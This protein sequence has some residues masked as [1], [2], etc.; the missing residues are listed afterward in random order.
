MPL[1]P[2]QEV[3]LMGVPLTKKGLQPYNPFGEYLSKF[4]TL[5]SPPYSSME[6]QR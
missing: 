1:R 5:I 3:N 2:V 6:K 4:I